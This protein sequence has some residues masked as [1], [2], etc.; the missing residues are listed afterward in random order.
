ML[1]ELKKLNGIPEITIPKAT[2]ADF[3]TLYLKVQ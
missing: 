3:N 1:T 2:K